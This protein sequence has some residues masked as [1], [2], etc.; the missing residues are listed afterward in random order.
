M[1]ALFYFAGSVYLNQS[2]P[3]GRPLQTLA[4]ISHAREEEEEEEGDEEANTLNESSFLPGTP[5]S[6]KVST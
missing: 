6:K 1:L 3:A 2:T 4:A 5:P